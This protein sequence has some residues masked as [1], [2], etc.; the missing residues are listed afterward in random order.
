MSTHRR[1][2]VFPAEATRQ[3]VNDQR[4]IHLR[5]FGLFILLA[6]ALVGCAPSR[7][8][9]H[10]IPANRCAWHLR[11]PTPSTTGMQILSRTTEAW[12][13]VGSVDSTARGYILLARGRPNWFVGQL[14]GGGGHVNGGRRDHIWKAGYLSYRLTYDPSSNTADLLG[15]RIWLDTANVL[16]V[17]HVDQ[18]GSAQLVGTGCVVEFDLENPNSSLLSVSP[19]VR[20]YV[21]GR[22]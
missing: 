3:T 7:L 21:T 8:S 19:E 22:Q 2:G 14:V 18:S 17:D 13:S 5:V 20:A 12:F 4:M 11:S 10:G 9:Q 16:L 15:K 1:R 6:F